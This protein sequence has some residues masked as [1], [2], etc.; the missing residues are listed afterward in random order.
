MLT[1]NMYQMQLNQDHY[2]NKF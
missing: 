2:F 1:S